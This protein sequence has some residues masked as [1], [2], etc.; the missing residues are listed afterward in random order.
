V[1]PSRDLA[2]PSKAPS[3][4]HPDDR[5]PQI[6]PGARSDM[7]AVDALYQSTGWTAPGCIRP[8]DVYLLARVR[9]ELVGVLMYRLEE[10]DLLPREGAQ[11]PYA[12]SHRLWVS[13]LAVAAP[14]RRS[15]VGRALMHAAAAAA[16]DEHIGWI[17]TWPF[18]VGTEAERAGR[19]SFFASCGLRP[20]HPKSHTLEMVGATSTIL[21]A[22][23]F[24]G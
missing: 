11:A 12:T 13:E 8:R 2:A 6:S 16:R 22:T 23:A 1:N 17:R 19:V 18:P 24:D 3:E 7:A 20:W 15:G 4:P 21:G 10:P 9:R 5:A 14:V